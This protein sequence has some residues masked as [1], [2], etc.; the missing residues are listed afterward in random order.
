MKIVEQIKATRQAGVPIIGIETSDPAETMRR[1]CSALNGNTDAIPIL[2][3]DCAALL[4]SK[5]AGGIEAVNTILGGNDPAMMV[6][7]AGDMLTAAIQAPDNTVLFMLGAPL[8]IR[9][10][11]VRQAVWN[12]RDNWKSRNA[13]LVLLGDKISLPIELVDDVMVLR[14]PLPT[15]EELE[16]VM[17]KTL[18]DANEAGANVKADKATMLRA[19]QTLT[20]MSAF[21]AEQQLAVSLGRAGVD[22]DY[23]WERK[24]QTIQA[25]QGLS[26]WRGNESFDRIGGCEEIKKKLRALMKGPMAPRCI[27]FIDE[28]EKALAG[29]DTETSGTTSDFLGVILRVTQDRKQTGFIFLGPPG[30]AKSEMAK[31][32]GNEAGIPTIQVD[33][34]GAKSRYVGDS[35]ANIR[36]QMDVISAVSEDKALWIVT[37]NSLAALK[38]EL[39]RRFYLGIYFF[40]LPNAEERKAIWPIHAV[41]LGLG[42]QPRPNDNGWTGAEIRACCMKAWAMGMT[43]EDAGKSIIPISRSSGQEIETMRREASG[44]FLSVT[45]EGAYAFNPPENI[46]EPTAR[47]RR[48]FGVRE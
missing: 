9:S 14:D 26:V 3:W 4:R 11:R 33:L 27:V 25:V 6:G 29:S 10:E 31:A 16:S 40:D 5:N 39:R 19:A 45:G 20:G 37:C 43:L 42:K 41:P 22:W 28:I 23:L 13:Q 38:K 1:Y 12:I 32:A 46:M 2:T 24:V 34:G 36:R 18:R 21:A 35:E 44:R 7:N 47:E 17:G 30:C 8:Y 15:V 48:S